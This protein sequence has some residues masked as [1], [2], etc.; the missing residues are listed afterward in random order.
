MSFTF[1]QF[2]G[3]HIFLVVADLIYGVLDKIITSFYDNILSP[4]I[5]IVIGKNIIKK[6]EVSIG[7]NEN[8]G[9]LKFGDF[10]S[11]TIKMLIILLI[12]FNIYISFKQFEKYRKLKK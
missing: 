6:M 5:N 1:S 9:I 2:A 7:S 3:L 4:L 11:E 8:K 12:I 10:I